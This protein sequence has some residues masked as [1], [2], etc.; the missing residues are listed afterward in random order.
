MKNWFKKQFRKKSRVYIFPTRMGGYLIGLIF[1]MFLLSIGYNNNLL[2]IFTLCLFG[3]NILWV[4]QCHYHLHKL[5][6]SHIS[7]SHGH[8]GDGLLLSIHW[9]QSPTNP[10]DWKFELESDGPR[11]KVNSLN[12]NHESSLGEVKLSKRGKW[13]WK[14]LKTSTDL[15]YGLYNVWRF[16]PVHFSTLSYPALMKIPFSFKAEGEQRDG[17]SVTGRK[18]MEDLFEL[19]RYQIGE[20]SRRISWKHY[21]KKGDLLIKNGEELQ[22]A[23][24]KIRL[25]LP[26]NR[27]QREEYLSLVATQM[28]QC[29]NQQVP[30][31][32]EYAGQVLGPSSEKI[33]LNE[34]LK[35]I[36]LC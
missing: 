35:V 3:L 23:V 9:K 7:L 18:G 28:V 4:I 22:D 6:F 33:H 25:K 27:Y 12:S 19:N 26:E 13:D 16:D 20:E 21:A 30:F 5:R 10:V 1:L 14:Y 34:C 31:I 29:H 17:H 11:T 2:L 8:V 15:P 36:T 32:L 24:F